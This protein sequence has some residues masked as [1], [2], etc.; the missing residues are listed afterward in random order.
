MSSR[1]LCEAWTEYLV[2]TT[3]EDAEAPLWTLD[4][5]K[6]ENNSISNW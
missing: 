3:V 5:G 2:T 4:K 1:A 6:E